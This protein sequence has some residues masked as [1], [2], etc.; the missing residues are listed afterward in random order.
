MHT[1]RSTAL[2]AFLLIAGTAAAG[3]QGRGRGHDQDKDKDKHEAGG[4]VEV[5][6]PQE[7]QRRVEIERER[8]THYRDDYNRQLAAIRAQNAELQNQQRLEALRTQQAY[9]AERAR[10]GRE[11]QIEREYNRE[12]YVTAPH[13]YRYMIGG[14]PRETN[15]YGVDV[16]RRAVQYGYQQGYQAGMSDRR[17]HWR[18]DYRNAVAYRDANYG[19]RGAYVDQ[20]DY[21]YYF[22][23]GFQRGYED[24][25]SQRY[26]YGQYTNGSA[27]ILSNVLNSILGLVPLR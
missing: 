18:D 9:A 15:Q 2:V 13:V 6:S 26:Q 21:N 27:S 8:T 22:R 4:R 23:E 14:T 24:G 20:S 7:Q 11:I 16:L 5:V 12:P 25:Y 10:E 19:Y 17:D 3:A 1:P